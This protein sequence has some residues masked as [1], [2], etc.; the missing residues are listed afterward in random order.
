MTFSEYATNRCLNK[1][2]DVSLIFLW[3]NI[4][5]LLWHKASLQSSWLRCLSAFPISS[6][7]SYNLLVMLPVNV[8][9]WG[10][11]NPDIPDRQERRVGFDNLCSGMSAE[12][13][14]LVNFLLTCSCF[15]W[16]SF[17]LSHIPEIVGCTPFPFSWWLSEATCPLIRPTILSMYG[18][19]LPQ[20]VHTTSFLCL[21]MWLRDRD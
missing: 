13:N 3:D 8:F 16:F 12:R 5:M 14:A 15:F 2:A 4:V 9:G 18:I 7:V 6:V 1:W 11:L 10:M 21:L 19:C 17:S 20:A